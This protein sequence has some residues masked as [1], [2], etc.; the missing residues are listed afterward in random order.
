M[1]LIKDIIR[2]FYPLL[3]MCACVSFVVY[4]FFC[5]DYN[6]GMGIFENTGN[7]YVPMIKG[8]EVEHD[9]LNYIGEEVNSYVP[10]IKYN[11]GAKQVGDCITFKELFLVKK[12]DGSW[13][14]GD[15]ED[16][17]ALY[18]KDISQSEN[19][20]LEYMSSEEIENMEEVPA[21]FVYDK[22]NDLLYI[23]GSGT[24]C[25]EVKVYGKGGATQ[26]YEFNLP[27][28]IS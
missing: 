6:G 24:F 10:E 20:V 17:F 12:E 23:Y 15:T 1:E 9:G 25:V 21:A 16:D 27:V 8:D 11:S 3:I 22:E 14:T 18:L 5:A 4:V 26:I 13:A 2:Q 28:E 19:S 7:I